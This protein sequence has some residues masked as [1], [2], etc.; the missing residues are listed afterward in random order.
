[1]EGFVADIPG[2]IENQSQY[3][4]LDPLYDFGVRWFGTSPKL[5]PV[6][7]YWFQNHFV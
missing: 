3:F 1:M 7:P 6:G 5:Y 4:G 2:R